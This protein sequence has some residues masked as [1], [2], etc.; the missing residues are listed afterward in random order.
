MVKYIITLVLL[1]ICI[2][3]MAQPI[4]VNSVTEE[5]GS[6]IVYYPSETKFPNNSVTDNNDGTVSIQFLLGGTPPNLSNDTCSQGQSAYEDGFLYV[7]VADDTWQQVAIAAWTNFLL[8]SDG[9]S[10]ILLSDGTSFL[11]YR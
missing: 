3:V 4:S 2:T 9:S 11:L 10:K 8:L 6:P 5:D 1:F 7:C